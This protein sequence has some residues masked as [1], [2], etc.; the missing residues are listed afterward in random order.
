M[1]MFRGTYVAL[2]TPF[3]NGKVDF[4]TLERLVEFHVGAG[5]AGIVPCGTTGESP[6][7][8]HKEHDQV[9]E[10]V[11][12]FARGRIHVMAGTG[13][14]AT[15]EAIELTQHAE[16]A[17]AD[18][19]L[20]VSPYYNKPTQDGL[21]HHFKAIAEATSLP[22]VLYNIPG[23]CAVE[24]ATDTIVRLAE[25]KT[26][27]AV[28][29]ATGSMDGASELR[30]RCGLDILSGDD[31]MTLPLMSIGGT[32]VISVIAN[33]IPKDM[34][35]LTDAALAGDFKTA[36]QWHRKT[37]ALAKGMLSMATNPIPVKAAM[38]ML[39]MCEGE[40]RLPMY[41][42]NEALKAKLRQMAVEYGLLKK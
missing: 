20:Q 15:D 1:S 39:G 5:I 33:V 26:I 12:K 35:A 6:T 24:I 7:L 10:E 41:P 28:K 40:L 30:T 37:F 29:H 8:S 16:R 11:V 31:S 38:D 4:S 42:M 21:Y 17:G 34:K 2:V 13:S 27:A 14:N 23:R 19:T 32:G 3:K 25:I 36:E 18:S 9:I 22:V